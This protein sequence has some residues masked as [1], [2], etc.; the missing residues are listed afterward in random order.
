MWFMEGG[1]FHIPGHSMMMMMTSNLPES[2]TLLVNMVR[3]PL[4]DTICLLYTSPSPRD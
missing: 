4:L 3:T 2:G 1:I